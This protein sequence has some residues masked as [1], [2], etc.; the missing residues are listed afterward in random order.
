MNRDS[1]PETIFLKTTLAW[2]QNDNEKQSFTTKSQ[3]YYQINGKRFGNKKQKAIRQLEAKHELGFEQKSLFDWIKNWKRFLPW[4]SDSDL[5]YSKIREIRE[6]W[7]EGKCEIREKRNEGKWKE[8]IW[9]IKNW[10]I[11]NIYRF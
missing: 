3:L 10:N 7:K 1:C 5:F 9:V 6:K 8:W 4:R 11:I 2:K